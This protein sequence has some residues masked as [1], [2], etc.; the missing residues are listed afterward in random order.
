MLPWRVDFGWVSGWEIVELFNKRF[1][2]FSYF[3]FTSN[4]CHIMIT[5]HKWMLDIVR[6]FWGF[7]F[8]VICFFLL[9]FFHSSFSCWRNLRHVEG[10]FTAFKCQICYVFNMFHFFLS[11]CIITSSPTTLSE[12]WWR[13]NVPNVFTLLFSS[14]FSFFCSF[15]FFSVCLWEIQFSISFRARENV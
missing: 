14:F 8:V 5:H 11:S 13:W 12:W 1:S 9:Y 6:L 15:L 4:A 2:L 3:L 10:P 7:F